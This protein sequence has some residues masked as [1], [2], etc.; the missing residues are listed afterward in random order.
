MGV[1]VFRGL[2]VAQ[3]DGG[4]KSSFGFVG[5]VDFKLVQVAEG[6][7]GMLEQFFHL[8]AD[9]LLLDFADQGAHTDPLCT[10]IAQ[11]GLSQH[12]G[13]GVLDCFN[14][15]LRHKNAA[16]GGTFLPSFGRHFAANFFE[17]KVKIGTSR[18]HIR[19]QHDSVE[20]IGFHIE[21]D[22]VLDD[23]GQ[24]PQLLASSCRTGKCYDVLL[25]QVIQNT[26]PAATN[27]LQCTLW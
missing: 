12:F 16:N 23:A 1:G 25:T 24:G 3:E 26:Y 10:W 18:F 21:R 2:I 8:L 15:T 20:T 9:F 11:L 19:S 13:Q 6:Q 14:P 27:Q 4:K 22:T 17:E 5:T 7:A